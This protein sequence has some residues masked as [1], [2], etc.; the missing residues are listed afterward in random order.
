V[1]LV[2]VAAAFAASNSTN[3]PPGAAG[4][5]PAP[6]VAR[7]ATWE[8]WQHVP[9]I[10]DV[11]GPRKDG[12]MVAAVNG[13][14]ALLAPDGKLEAFAPT[15]KYDAGSEAYLAESPGL[16]LSDA[17]CSFGNNEVEVLKVSAPFGVT[18]I[19]PS[20]NQGQLA[21]VTGVDGLSAIAFDLGGK[22]GHR[23]LVAGP[24]G[25]HM[26]VLAIDC[27]GKVSMVAANVPKFEGGVAV[28]PATFGR[29]AGWLVGPDENS[30]KIL[31]VDAAG[32]SSLVA[33]SGLAVG[34]DIGVESIGFV[35]KGLFATRGNAYLADRG[36]A[37]S[38]HPG[39]DS[40][41]RLTAAALQAAGVQ[42]GDLLAATEGGGETIAVRCGP[43]T[44]TVIKVGSGPAVGHIEGHIAFSFR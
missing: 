22:F 15:Y 14:L 4:I 19:D 39:T 6:V 32:K 31:A 21:T 9:G 33:D 42:E 5:S 1:L 40:V 17:G 11:D 3:R 29:F 2:A 8:T 30:G 24:S 41:L 10:L 44:C 38:P 25:D 20:G 16:N 37:G 36:T 28:A 12:R 27:K 26:V 23:L 18:R 34:G 35:P 7:P 13:H 43:S